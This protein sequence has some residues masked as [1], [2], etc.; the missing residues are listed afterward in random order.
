MK[1]LLSI[2]FLMVVTISN[3]QWCNPSTSGGTIT[4]AAGT[5]T[6][7][8]F[9][10]RVY[11]T[12]AA[13]A[14][15]EYTFSTCGLSAADTRIRIYDATGGTLLAN[16]D[17]FCGLQS[18]LTVLFNVSGTFTVHVSQ[19]ACANLGSST[20]LS[21][22]RNCTFTDN[23]CYGATQICNDAP[24]SANTAGFGNYQELNASNQ[25]CLFVE[26]QSYWYYFQ[27]V[28][29]GTVSFNINTCATCDYDFALWAS[30]NCGALGAPV[31]CSYSSLQ[32]TT[33]LQNTNLGTPSGCGFGGLSACPPGP[34]SDQTEGTGGDKF[35][36][37]LNVVA[38]QTYILLIDNYTANNQSFDIDFTFSSSGLLD[39]TPVV[40]PVQLISFEGS[41]SAKGNLITWV[42]ASERE[43]SHFNLYYS[44][45]GKQFDLLTSMKGAGS[46]VT[47]NNYEYTHEN[48][49]KGIGYY[50]LEQ[51]DENG[52]VN[53]QRIISVVNQDDSY[54]DAIYPN[55][56][57]EEFSFNYSIGENQRATVVLYDLAGNRLQNWELDNQSSI[58]TTKVQ[59]QK[60]IYFVQFLL[61]G[62]AVK[63]QKWV[64]E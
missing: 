22:S 18:Q 62:K 47:Q 30:N 42:T 28:M 29:N 9:T 44:V 19:N 60:G 55:P 49:T 51:V 52:A 57:K 41:H 45:D 21:Y 63:T 35:V 48:P 31:R 33:G 5:Q 20:Q 13:S 12:F 32:G 50:K 27:P 43:N 17:D 6:T 36:T 26:H 59:S 34:V 56:S 8:A 1:A 11:F 37:P 23:E 14:G 10:G 38:G 54:F 39:C 16:N 46:V 3:A 2:A 58:F 64:K 4:P 7:G 15:C 25:G 53:Q 24:F 61:D 40:L